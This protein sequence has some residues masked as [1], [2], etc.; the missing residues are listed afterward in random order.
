MC[1]ILPK[2][3]L[4]AHLDCQVT[5]ISKCVSK[6]IFE[7]IVH[8]LGFEP[9]TSYLNP[10]PHTWESVA[11]PIR[12]QLSNVILFNFF[13]FN[14]LHSANWTTLC[15]LVVITWSGVYGV[16]QLKYRCRQFQE[17]YRRD[18]QREWQTQNFLIYIYRERDKSKMH[19]KKQCRID[20][21]ARFNYT[22]TF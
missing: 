6:S 1:L 2:S 14:P 4:K 20:E 9:P 12:L 11:L 15:K 16:R 19:C 7:K 18:G 10:L 22:E 21:M 8:Q 13:I 17:S 5:M 3:H